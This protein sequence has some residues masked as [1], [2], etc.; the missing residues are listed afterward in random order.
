MTLYLILVYIIQLTNNMFAGY[1]NTKISSL[2]FSLRDLFFVIF[3]KIHV[4]FLV[5]FL[6]VTGTT[7]YALSATPIYIVSA[8]ILLKPFFDSTQAL[9]P[10]VLNVF[11]IT[12]NDMNTAV[13]I[14]KSRELALD[15]IRKLE[16]EYPEQK[17]NFL[18]RMGISSRSTPEESA[19]NYIIS[20]L[21]VYTVTTSSAI[22]IE[23]TGTNPEEITKIVNA[24]LECY[25]DRHIKI[26][27]SRN[28]IKFYEEGVKEKRNEL[29]KLQRK[30]NEK[31]EKYNI[32][33]I[34][35]QKRNLLEILR[36]FEE[37]L[38]SILSNI[39]EKQIV[40][41]EIVNNK[42][43]VSTKEFRDS[44]FTDLTAQYVSLLFEKE[45][46]TIL[47]NKNSLEYIKIDDKI[48][49]LLRIIKV[50]KEKIIKGLQIEI[51]SLHEKKKVFEEKI[52]KA[53][54]ELTRLSSIEVDYTDLIKSIEYARRIY[55]IYLE[56]LE[57]EKIKDQRNMSGISNISII[58]SAHV[59]SIPIFPKKTFMIAVA[60]IAGS[61]AAIGLAFIT[62][63]IDFTVK[64]PKE[65]MAIVEAPVISLEEI[66]S[67]SL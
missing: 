47:Y 66:K 56:K 4:V 39:S 13:E 28:E 36:S 1:S 52:V 9:T 62:Y 43:N 5:F 19:I 32:I 55:N 45:K 60:I 30:L 37:A 50:E 40:V 53:K 25:I 44:M 49:N 15:V 14:L 63:Y 46:V 24:Y 41:N 27:R 67:N 51:K 64:E 18:I 42:L 38:S 31:I 7:L 10:G 3:Y 54:E 61:G 20:S 35:N 21:S 2:R 12:Q 34:E 6:I 11:P 23:R 8:H 29:D 17:D 58:N 22:R 33:N 59:P 57:E 26:Y 48:E 65:I 16:I